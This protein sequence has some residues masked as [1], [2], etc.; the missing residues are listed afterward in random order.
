MDDGWSGCLALKDRNQGSET[1]RQR[2]RP[3]YEQNN[4]LR[5]DGPARQLTDCPY[6]HSAVSHFCVA[7]DRNRRITAERFE[8]YRCEACGLITLHPIP[9]DL[10]RY[11]PTDYYRV[12]KRVEEIRPLLRSERY[13]VDLVSRLAA[14]R[15]LL[16]IGPA[17]GCFALLA[18]EAGFL[19]DTIEMDRDCCRFLTEQ[20]QVR[21]VEHADPLAVLPSLGAYDVIALWHVVEHVTQPWTIVRAAA[22]QLA[23]GGILVIATPNPDALQLRVFGPHWTHLDAP[24]HV[25]LIPVQLLQTW[26]GEE[27]TDTELATTVDPGSLNW[28][29]FGWQRSLMA[30]ASNRL[31]RLARQCVGKLTGIAIAPIER[32]RW[33]GACYT[34]VF[35]RREAA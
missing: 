10:G 5:M 6:C 14:G 12:P 30:S 3:G 21:A 27:R 20:I 24:R 7:T 29:Q 32:R 23:P 2:N 16:E 25:H 17:I 9:A 15:R 13:K 33:R 18:K 19:V 28:N 4:G 22:R 26:A 8:Y 11:Y 31:T 1:E 34:T 35:R